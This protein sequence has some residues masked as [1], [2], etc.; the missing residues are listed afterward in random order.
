MFFKFKSNIMEN[1]QILYFYLKLS[2]VLS[3]LMPP[4]KNKKN[5]RAKASKKQRNIY[6]LTI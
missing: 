5:I 3:R 1:S 4:P 2:Q 6:K